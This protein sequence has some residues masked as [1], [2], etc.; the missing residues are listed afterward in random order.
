M[1]F[2]NSFANCSISAVEMDLCGVGAR[3]GVCGLVS[4]TGSIKKPS[5]PL[6]NIDNHIWKL[7][8]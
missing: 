6:Q 2:L 5:N 8:V 4:C 1:P 7:K 3:L